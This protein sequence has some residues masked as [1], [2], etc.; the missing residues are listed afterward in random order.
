MRTNPFTEAQDFLW[1][2]LNPIASG[3][4]EYMCIALTFAYDKKQIG[5]TVCIQAQRMIHRRLGKKYGTVNAYLSEELKLPFAVLTD[6]NVQSFRFF[7]LAHL[8]Q[9][10]NQGIR[11]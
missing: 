9:L 8:E 10:W 4:I 11:K 5:K 2:G 1:R 6:L 3:Q 7:W